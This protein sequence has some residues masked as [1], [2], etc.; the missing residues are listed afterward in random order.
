MERILTGIK[1]T[2]DLHLGHYFGV[3]KPLLHYPKNLSIFLAD[4]HAHTGVY[5]KDSLYKIL[6]AFL[7]LGF[8]YKKHSLYAQSDIPEIF[9]MSWYLSCYLPKS[10]LNRA[11]AYKTLRDLNKKNH[12]EEDYKIST[13]LYTYPVLMAAD[14]LIFNATHVPIGSDQQQHID[15]TRDIARIFN[16][17]HKTNFFILPE[18]IIS[19]ELFP[20]IDG[21]K[22]SKS[23]QNTLP[24]FFN[25]DSLLKTILKIPTDSLPPGAPKPIESNLFK[26][27]SFFTDTVHLEKIYQE[28]ISWKEAK[29]LFFEDL[30]KELSPFQEKYQDFLENK[31]VLDQILLEGA[32]KVL[33]SAKQKI[34]DFLTFF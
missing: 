9:Q 24:L 15:I 5:T 23:Y 25:K 11:H 33:P 27:H 32:E 12:K 3:L 19:Q 21:R 8:D 20:G 1:C 6:S 17:Q 13:G 14:I 18:A 28:G 22:M 16:E 10:Y 34:K 31:T 29:E 7:A 26:M 30:V 2:G 4:G